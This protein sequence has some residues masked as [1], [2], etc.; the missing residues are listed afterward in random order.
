MARAAGER[1]LAALE[2]ALAEVRLTA[3]PEAT[4]IPLAATAILLVELAGSDDKLDPAAL[5]ALEL[6]A[7]ERWGVGMVTRPPVAG[8]DFLSHARRAAAATDHA[9]RIG[10]AAHVWHLTLAEGGLSAHGAALLDRVALFLSLTPADMAAARGLAD[11]PG[12]APPP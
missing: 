10:L 6:Y 1:L 2:A 8:D 12:G 4:P 5:T 7:K 11:R 9:D 3:R